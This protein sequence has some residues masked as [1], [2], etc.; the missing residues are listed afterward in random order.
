MRNEKVN[1]FAV[2][3]A[4]VLCQVIGYLWYS[5]FL[6]GPRWMALVGKSAEELKSGGA[7]PYVCAILGSLLIS[8]VLAKIIYATHSNTVGQGIAMGFIIWLGFIFPVICIINIFAGRAFE[9]T[10]INAG[11]FLADMLVAGGVLAVFR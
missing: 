2:I 1:P 7:L 10:L 3:L 9:L 6:F 11:H 4:A 8:F 5:P